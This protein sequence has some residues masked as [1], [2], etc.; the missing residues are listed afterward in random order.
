MSAFDER[1]RLLI[2]DEGAARL[3]GARVAVLG[4]GGVGSSCAEALARAGVGSLVLLDRDVVEPSNINRQALAFV[5]TVGRPKAEVMAA[6]VADINPGCQAI[7]CEQYLERGRVAE[8]LSV[9]ARP[10]YVVDAIDTISQKVE[11]AAWCQSEGIPLVSAAGGANKLDPCALAFA[12]LY[13]TSVCPL[14]KDLRRM[15]RERGLAGW[16]VLYSRERPV[17]VADP[18]NGAAGERVLG[19]MSYLPPIM[20]QMIASRVVRDIAGIDESALERSHT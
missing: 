12:D 5:S 13:E 4:L 20:G 19:T 3:A 11:I 18:A 10:D 6:M 15:A 7:A 17:R 14:A 16:C 1:T 8:Q 2:G 9:I